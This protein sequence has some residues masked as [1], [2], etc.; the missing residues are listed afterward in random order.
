[1]CEK[2]AQGLA[3]RQGSQKYYWRG[4]FNPKEIQR[5]NGTGAALQTSFP[6]LAG[7]YVGFCGID[8]SAGLGGIG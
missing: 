5:D 7:G 4:S 2:I 1:M 6:W 3:Q 8:S